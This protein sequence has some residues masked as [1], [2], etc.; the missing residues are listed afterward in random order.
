MA[1]SER[2]FF[3]GVATSA[4]LIGLGFG[5]GI[6]L[7]RAAL[8]P[9]HQTK[10]A[11]SKAAPSG[12]AERSL[13]PARVVLPA[14]TEATS[15]PPTPS[16]APSALDVTPTASEPQLTSP[17]ND[18]QV[19][20]EKEKQ[21][22]HRAEAAKKKAETAERSK[23]AADRDRHRRYAERK[24]RQDAALELQRVQEPRQEAPRRSAGPFGMLAFD[25]GGQPP[26]QVGFF[27]Y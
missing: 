27:G 16:S 12:L 8:E 26:R 9:A 13:P 22:E 6:L 3:T 1:S 25:D 10:T 14:L 17:Q 20:S 18:A 11:E 4:L 24:A 5:G 2:I 19:A 7:G 21:A 23:K 15:K